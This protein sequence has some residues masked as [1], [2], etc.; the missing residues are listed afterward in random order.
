MSIKLP[1]RSQ[2][3]AVPTSDRDEVQDGYA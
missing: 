3:R 1:F 2:Y